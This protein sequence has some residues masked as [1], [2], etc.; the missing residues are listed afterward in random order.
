M[1]RENM[2]KKTDFLAYV[3]KKSTTT[4]VFC[5]VVFAAFSQTAHCLCPNVTLCSGVRRNTN[6]CQKWSWSRT[7]SLRNPSE[8]QTECEKRVANFLIRKVAFG[9]PKSR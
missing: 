4:L 9:G 2:I 5:F 1:S 6:L 3:K 8:D 7:N